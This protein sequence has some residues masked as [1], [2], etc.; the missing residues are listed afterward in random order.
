MLQDVIGLYRDGK[1]KAFDPLKVFEAAEVSQAFRH[2]S[3]KNRMGKIAVSFEND[4]SMISVRVSL[5]L[6]LPLPLP[7][8]LLY[9]P[10]NTVLQILPTKYSCVFSPTK[11]YLLAGCLGG[12]GR[13]ITKWMMTRG[14]KKFAM[15]GRSGLDKEPA[16]RLVKDIQDSGADVHVTRGDVSDATV[17]DEAVAAIEGEIGGVVQAAMG[18][19]VCLTALLSP[20]LLRPS[21]VSSSSVSQLYQI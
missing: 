6:P 10:S 13:S 20:F 11:T 16:R 18:L 15:I 14:A 3:G 5:F 17:V 1:I 7:L 9:C 2:F 12:I 8:L 21:L 19:D 4:A